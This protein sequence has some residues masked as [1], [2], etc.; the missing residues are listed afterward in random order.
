MLERDLQLLERLEG[1]S[2]ETLQGVVCRVVWANR[3]PV[4]GSSAP[5]G[6]WN[7]ADGKFEVLNTSLTSEGAGA[8]FEA[9]WY[10]FDQRPDRPALNWK[11]R[12]RLKR[13]VELDFGQLDWLGVGQ[14]NYQGRDYSRTQAIS[15]ALHHLGC[16]GLIVPSA[17]Y[18]CRN[19]V[20][21]MQNLDKDCFVEEEEWIEF[22]WSDVVK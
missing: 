10:L 9:F 12:V 3:S 7:S 6:R 15:G 13:V 21:Y 14:A 16:D 20:V 11:L 22:S 1:C 4:H 19:L 18:E 17:R 8:E 5:R 2:Q